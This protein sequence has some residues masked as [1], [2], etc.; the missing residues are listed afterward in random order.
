MNAWRLPRRR[1]GCL[2]ADKGS[3][4]RRHY[5][6]RCCR[7]PH[8]GGLGLGRLLAGLH[9]RTATAGA[10]SMMDDLAWYGELL[11]IILGL[12]EMAD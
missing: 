9:G 4:L 2:V 12:K 7:F 11:E 10:R 8:G 6:R 5:H 3:R 1:F